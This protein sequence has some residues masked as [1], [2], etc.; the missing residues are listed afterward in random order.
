MKTELYL[1]DFVSYSQHTTDIIVGSKRLLVGM[2]HILGN[3]A[4]NILS[5]TLFIPFVLLLKYLYHRLAAKIPTLN[6]KITSAEDYVSI[7]QDYDKLNGL[8]VILTQIQ[9]SNRDN[10]PFALWFVAKEMDNI[11]GV[12]QQ[13]NGAFKTALDNLDAPVSNTLFRQ[14][15]E[16]EMWAAHVPA[17]QYRM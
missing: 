1:S 9:V 10:L 11:V 8:L 12:M 7:R 4:V 15:P 17:Y 2:K 6:L 3:L 16:A 13:L 5:V 14:I